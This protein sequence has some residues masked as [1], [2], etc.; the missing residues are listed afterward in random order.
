MKVLMLFAAVVVA[1]LTLSA[2]NAHAVQ[3]VEKQA[4]WSS[5]TPDTTFIADES[6]SD[7]VNVDTSDWFWPEGNDAAASSPYVQAFVTFVAQTSD[8]DADSIYFVPQIG[9]TSRNAAGA[10]VTVWQNWAAGPTAAAGHVAVI[11][12]G[13]G[14]TANVR[15]DGVLLADADAMQTS[16][17]CY[18]AVKLRL[19]V[20]GDQGGT[21]P[22]LSGVRCFIR[23][24]K[25]SGTF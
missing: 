13:L 24:P 19:R 14:G 25:R 16:L 15:Y 10:L 6:D 11:T 4:F 8:T 17:N 22:K 12:Q 5:S 23:Y 7:F 20:Q 1:A 9:V 18:G 3:W 21:T 2:P